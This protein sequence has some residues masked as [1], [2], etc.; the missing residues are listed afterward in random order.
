MALQSIQHI[1]VIPKTIKSSIFYINNNFK[2]SHYKEKNDL[3]QF[4]A[5]MIKPPATTQVHECIFNHLPFYVDIKNN[6]VQKMSYDKAA[7]INKL[8]MKIKKNAMKNLLK[9]LSENRSQED[10]TIPLYQNLADVTI[11]KT[12]YGDNKENSQDG[13]IQKRTKDNSSRI[14]NL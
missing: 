10:T 5:A 13:E 1:V 3:Y 11:N 2:D 7:E 12:L 4:I 8:K 6:I 9:D 14:E